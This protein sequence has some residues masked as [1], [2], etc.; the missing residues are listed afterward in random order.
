[1]SDECKLGS[2]ACD[3]C[4]RTKQSCSKHPIQCQRCTELGTSCT[5]SFGKFMGRPKKSLRSRRQFQ[6]DADGD[7]RRQ[8]NTSIHIDTSNISTEGLPHQS[9]ICLQFLQKDT[10]IDEAQN[11]IPQSTS[12]AKPDGKFV[13]LL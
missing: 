1:M 4:F 7:S 6:N 12:L 3:Q 10:G 13:R 2:N 9:S 11:P 8:P 5:Y